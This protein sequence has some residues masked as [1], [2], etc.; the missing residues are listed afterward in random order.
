MDPINYIA[1]SI[2]KP[3]DELLGTPCQELSQ[4]A[5]GHLQHSTCLT[6]KHPTPW[7]T[8]CMVLKVERLSFCR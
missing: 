2:K 7:L 5:Q 1:D 4:L 3:N 8:L 6:N